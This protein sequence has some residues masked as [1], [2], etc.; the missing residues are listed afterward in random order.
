MHRRYAFA[1]PLIG[2]ALALA[3]CGANSSTAPIS[4]TST[5]ATWNADLAA[6]D[7]ADINNYVH[8]ALNGTG[9]P[10]GSA[11]Q[12]RA[13]TTKECA[14]N[15]AENVSGVVGAFVLEAAG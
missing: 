12:V 8:G 9:D 7:T 3:A 5:C 6:K 11:A 13:A 4:N 15:P 2:T 14:A 10:A 1:A